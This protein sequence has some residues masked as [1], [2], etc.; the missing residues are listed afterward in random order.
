MF[1]KIALSWQM[2]YEAR[3]CIKQHS[4]LFHYT[5]NGERGTIWPHHVIWT[6]SYSHT[7][8]RGA[9]GEGAPLAERK[10]KSTRGQRVQVSFRW[11]SHEGQR[12]LQHC[13][14]YANRTVHVLRQFFSRPVRKQKNASRKWAVTAKPDRCLPGPSY[15]QSGVKW[16]M[17]FWKCRRLGKPRSPHSTL[18]SKPFES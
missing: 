18:L 6:T 12:R 17:N 14:C 2:Q 7:A 16:L 15:N 4:H 5:R 1:N 11:L 9:G 10:G 13:R 3:W 8:V